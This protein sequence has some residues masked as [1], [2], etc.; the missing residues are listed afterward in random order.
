MSESRTE[1]DSH[2]NMTVVGRHCHV[3]AQT[4]RIA[5]VSPF[6]P[7]YDALS[8]VP[9]VDAVLAYDCPYTGVTCLLL[10]RNA[11]HIPSMTHNL[12]PPFII[13]EA[14][15]ELNDV[16]KIHV[17]EPNIEDHSLYYK[18]EDIRIPLSLNGVSSPTLSLAN[19]HQSNLKKLKW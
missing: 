17:K 1:L 9:I 13:Q 18:G 6:S 8:K 15:I 12:I 14:G 5:D 11:L 4:G 2:A 19:R 16:P 7:D 10:L 3:L